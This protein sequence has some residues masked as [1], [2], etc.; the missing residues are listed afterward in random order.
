MIDWVIVVGYLALSLGVGIPGQRY[1]GNVSHFLVAGR[2]LGLYIGIATLAATEIGTIRPRIT[3]GYKYG[4]AS[5]R[6]LPSQGWS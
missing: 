5:F 2:E 3:A 4:F 1:V 6:Q